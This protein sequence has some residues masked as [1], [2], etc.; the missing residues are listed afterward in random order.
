MVLVIPPVNAISITSIAAGTTIAI[1]VIEIKE[2]YD[3][4]KKASKA[5]KKGLKHVFR[6]HH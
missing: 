2:N 1:N 3:K 6:R 4:V 5:T